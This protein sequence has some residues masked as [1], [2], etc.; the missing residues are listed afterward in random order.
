MKLMQYHFGIQ[1]RFKNYHER[2]ANLSLFDT[3]PYTCEKIPKIA[4]HKK[5]MYSETEFTVLLVIRS[6]GRASSK[7]SEKTN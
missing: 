1:K 5:S 7:G 2:V 3:G 4:F 6:V